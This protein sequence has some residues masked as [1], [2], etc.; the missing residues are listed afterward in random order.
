MIR[1]VRA[2]TR[3]KHFLMRL[4]TFTLLISLVP[5]GVLGFF[6]YHNVQNSMRHDIEQANELYL[7][8]TVNAMELVVKQIG[9][10]FRQFVTNNTLTE[11]DMFPLGNYF[12]EISG[13]HTSTN[14]E[15]LLDYMVSKAKVLRS[16][17]DLLKLNEFICSVYY[18]N[19]SRGIVLTS[20]YLQYEIDKF[21]DAGWD[22]NLKPS[23][24]GY[25]LIMNVRGAMLEDGKIKRVVPV[26][27]RPLASNYTIVINLDA[28]AFYT[29]LISRLGVE[30]GTSVMVFSREGEPLLYDNDASKA[31]GIAFVQSIISAND[32][33]EIGG[34]KSHKVVADRQLVSWRSSEVLGWD[35]ANVTNLQT[36]YSNV[37]NIRNLFYIVSILLT[38]ATAILVVV[39]SRRI[40]RPVNHLLQFVK[41]GIP[42][43]SSG[44]KGGRPQGEFRIISDGL[45]DA[46]AAG[47]QLQLRLRESLP[48]YQEK[49]V[50][51]LIKK[52]AMPT[53]VVEERLDYLGI[54]LKTCGIVPILVSVDNGGRSGASIESEQIEQLLVIDSIASAVDE[55]HTHWVLE[56]EDDVY[57]VLVNCADH[58]MSSAF[59]IA[60][61]I[62]DTI[63]ENHEMNCSIGIGTF[64]KTIGDLPQAYQEAE[65]ALQYRGMTADS[66]VVYIEDV[67]L[68]AHDP[69]PY[70]KDMETTLIVCLKNGDKDQ[71]LAVFAEMVRDMR[72]KAEKVAFPQVQQTFLLLLV[73]LIETVRDLHLDMKEIVPG[74]RTH[75]LAVFLQKDEWRSMTVWF[76]GLI[77]S[78]AMYIGQAFQEKKNSHVEHAKRLIVSEPVGTVSLTSIA[79]RL[80]LNPAYL[81]RIF[82]EYTGVTFT[83]YV[84]QT[85]VSRSKEL[86][87][88]TELKVQDISEQLGYAKVNHFIKLFKDMTGI[89]PGEFRKQHD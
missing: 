48:A 71:A 24:L 27:Y 41:D 79:D 38:L 18:I 62:R 21:Y 33:A 7:N 66:D 40:Y 39:T 65:E 4:V 46:Y 63:Y 68:H 76:E 60:E 70:P 54:G 85:R 55:G 29:N 82:K 12:D 3:H 75:L 73:K 84:I 72:S 52:H 30:H 17:N 20:G 51:S 56:I 6:F 35:I 43:G 34:R 57:L 15:L 58:E 19:P 13:W 88:H 69:L 25:P 32:A 9:N 47:K 14:R 42:G 45:A 81:S 87:L 77:S 50:R 80:N 28:E 26:V 83:D 10:G 37:S 49:F 31:E 1:R 16:M 53:K 2:F 64:C 5:I 22:N 23:S 78:T 86:L 36:L 89:T 8:Q 74:E 61:T 11:F 59:S 67:R 44:L